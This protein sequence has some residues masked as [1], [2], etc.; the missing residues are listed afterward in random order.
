[1]KY[2]A[3]IIQYFKIVKWE[4]LFLK[5]YAQNVVEKLFQLYWLSIIVDQ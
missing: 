1:M 3:Y 2:N 4:T 5:N